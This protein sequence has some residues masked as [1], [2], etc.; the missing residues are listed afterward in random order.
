MITPNEIELLT[1]IS[2]TNQKSILKTAKIILEQRLEHC[3][4]KIREN[5][6]LWLNYKSY[7]LY[8]CRGCV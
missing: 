4:V 7:R 8:C 1:G 3:I 6:S 5:V 2:I